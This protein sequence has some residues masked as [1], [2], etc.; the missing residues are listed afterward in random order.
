MFQ[1]KDLDG[2]KLGHTVHLAHL[3]IFFFCLFM[4]LLTGQLEITI[5]EPVATLFPFPPLRRDSRD[6]QYEPVFLLTSAGF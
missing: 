5:C 1:H 2:Q 4:A 3:P 6:V